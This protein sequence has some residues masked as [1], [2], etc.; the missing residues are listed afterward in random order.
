MTD[1]ATT[2]QVI[3]EDLLSKLVCPVDKAKVELVESNLVCTEC[4]RQFKVEN[5]I[6]NMLIDDVR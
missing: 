3:S 4:G 6:P 5:G 2:K 1:S